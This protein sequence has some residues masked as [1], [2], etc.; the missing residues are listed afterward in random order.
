MWF[1]GNCKEITFFSAYRI[2]IAARRKDCVEAVVLVVPGKL[3]C[4]EKNILKKLLKKIQ[5]KN[6]AVP[7]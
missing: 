2:G 1:T 4:S 3:C 7:S 5:T 6:Y